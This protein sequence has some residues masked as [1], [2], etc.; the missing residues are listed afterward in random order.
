MPKVTIS[1]DQ[2]EQVAAMLDRW[3]G[4][5]NWDLVTAKVT[6]LFDIKGGVTRQNL[7]SKELIKIAFQQRKKKLREKAQSVNKNTNTS[8]EYLQ[9]QIEKLEAELEREKEKVARYEARFVRW[10]YNAYINGVAVDSL[11]NAVEMLEQP[12]HALNRQHRK[13]K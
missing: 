8:V 13:N 7:S 2:I 6:E 5:L 4:E 3:Q 1:D 9:G 12:L 10:Q 11:D